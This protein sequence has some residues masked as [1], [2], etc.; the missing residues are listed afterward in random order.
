MDDYWIGFLAGFGGSVFGLVIG[1]LL[2][3]GPTIRHSAP[4]KPELSITVDAQTGIPDTTYI[5]RKP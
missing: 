2:S 4:V 5:Y 1:V 3:G